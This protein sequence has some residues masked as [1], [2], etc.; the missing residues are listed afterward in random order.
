[1]K[2]VTLTRHAAGPR[3]DTRLDPCCRLP[4]TQVA[5]REL[6]LECNYAYEAAAQQRFRQL[7]SSDPELSSSFYVPRV[8]EELCSRQ[9]LTTEWVNGVTID[10]VGGRA[11]GRVVA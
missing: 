4:H 9:V 11:G 1:V 6:A 5:K 10:K 8:Y 2:R 3:D 7:V